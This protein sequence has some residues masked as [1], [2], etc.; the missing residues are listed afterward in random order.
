[1]L[2]DDRGWR[3]IPE[4]KRNT[5]EAQEHPAG[6]DPRAKHVRNFLDCMATREDPVMHVDVGHH[7]STV[8]HLGNLAMRTGQEVHWDAEQ[9]KVTNSSAADALVGEPYRAGWE[10]PYRRRA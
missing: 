9:E 4:P 6:P 1:V 8:A 2:I 5:L 7:V 3:V 10:L